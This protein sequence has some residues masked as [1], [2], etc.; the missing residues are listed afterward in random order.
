MENHQEKKAPKWHAKQ[1]CGAEYWEQTLVSFARATHHSNV[2]GKHNQK[3]LEQ[4]T[5]THK[6]RVGTN[7]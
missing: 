4:P 3:E 7:Y 6:A 1:E 5:I 2:R